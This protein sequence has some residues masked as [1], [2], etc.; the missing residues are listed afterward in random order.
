M[1]IS[2]KSKW[3]L[4]RVTALL[5]IP[6]SFWFIYQCLTFQKLQYFEL[7][8]F[9]QSYLNSLLFLAMMT[10]MLIH[11]KLGCETIITDYISSSSLKTLFKF[12]LNF[13]SYF[14]LFLVITAI[15]NLS[16]F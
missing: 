2:Y 10:V 13:I 11:A 16:I 14:S 9:F 8:L 12:I 5:L 15:I 3:V 6:L 1:K 7:K 4:Q